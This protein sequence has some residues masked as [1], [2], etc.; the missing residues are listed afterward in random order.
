MN[1]P[2]CYSENVVTWR[3]AN[4]YRCKNCGHA[5]QKKIKPFGYGG[6]YASA[7]DTRPAVE[8]SWVRLSHLWKFSRGSKVLDIGYGN[9]EFIRQARRAGYD[10]YGFDTHSEPTEGVRAVKDIS[11]QW[12][13]VTFFDSW[14][15]IKDLRFI[16]EIQSRLFVITIPNLP[17]LIDEKGL[18]L[19]KHYKPNEHLHYFTKASAFAFF[20]NNGYV[21]IDVS[22]IEDVIRTPSGHFANTLT[23]TIKRGS[24]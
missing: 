9:G 18:Q 12:D 14:E 8:M 4:V 22:D 19:W 5:W 3:K 11:G 6:E 23:F 13:V 20:L 1:C 21:V 24:L 15:H 17:P 10:A 7:Y 2:C 16:N